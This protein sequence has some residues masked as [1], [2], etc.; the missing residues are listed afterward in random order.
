MRDSRRRVLELLAQGKITVQE[1]EQLLSAVDGS[2][3][4]APD[5]SQA[6]TSPPRFLRVLIHK[7]ADEWRPAKDV[8]IRVPLA[9][10]RG[11]LRLG[12]VIPGLAGERV[13]QHLRERGI[14]IDLSKLDYA[15]LE[16]MLKEL[17]ELTIDVDGGK[18]QVRLRCE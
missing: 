2:R 1:A 10:V 7:T 16:S 14:D 6:G 3:P 18:A 11:G 9:F 8:N 17:G 13:R 5:S 12:S 4:D 15:E